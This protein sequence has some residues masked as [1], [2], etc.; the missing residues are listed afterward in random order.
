MPWIKAKLRG[1][2]VYARATEAGALFAQ[3]GRVEIRYNPHDGRMYRA[4]SRNLEVADGAEVLP[5][6]TC[7]SAEGV[8]AQG[9]KTVAKGG[10]KKKGA[11]TKSKK[12]QPVSPP[13]DGEIVAYTDGACSGN[14]GPAGLGVV[15]LFPDRRIEQSEYL[16]RATNNVAE[17]TAIFRALAEVQPDQPLVIY[18]DSSYSIGVLRKGWKAKA[19]QELIA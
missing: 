13:R 14:P 10:A 11:K 3:G 15:L 17:L 18:T 7:S 12:D 16:G 9:G 6:D 5:E 4:S 8:D 1:K 19:N 2:E